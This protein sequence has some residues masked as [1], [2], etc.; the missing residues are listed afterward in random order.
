[1]A[2][3]ETEDDTETSSDG[4]PDVGAAKAIKI[5]QERAQ[6]LA[7]SLAGRGDTLTKKVAILLNRY[8][9]TRDSDIALQLRYWRE[10]DEWNGAPVSEKDLYELTRL[11]S[12]A[13]SRARIQNVLG[14][15]QA[16]A[17]IRQR[18]GKLAE[19]EKERAIDVG[20]PAS[21]LA[22]F[23][24]ESGKNL[25]HLI[26]GGIW[27][28]D[29][30]ELFGLDR[31]IAD[32]RKRKNFKSELHFVDINDQNE[33]LYREAFEIVMANA[34]SISFKSLR[35]ERRGI[36]DVE[37]A[38]DELFYH[39]LVTGVRHEHETGRSPLP[40][41]LQFWKDQEDQNRDKLRLAT[42]R[43]RV[44]QAGKT[45]FDG[46]LR[47]G[48]FVPVES[49]QID[50]MQIADLFIGALNRRINTANATPKAKDRFSAYVLNKIGLPDGPDAPSGDFALDSVLGGTAARQ[51]VAA[52]G[53]SRRWTPR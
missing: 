32:W 45:V 44:L 29:S 6:L 47:V 18:R 7:D 40:K 5:E 17:P 1:M 30:H 19:D 48:D 12:I 39:L 53:A 35:L 46:R 13:R 52:D 9:E 8:P 23:A 27:F 28:G 43:D 14:L 20:P 36:R 3:D 31:A 21:A 11:T 34:S 22:V 33:A 51:G 2:V 16:S 50:M 24:D 26:V 10:Y 37:A 38:F 41:T 49:H 4:S 42:L 25:D 15:F